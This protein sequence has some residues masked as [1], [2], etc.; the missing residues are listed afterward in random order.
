[1]GLAKREMPRPRVS[2]LMITYNHER[3]IQQA[4]EGVIMQKP[5]FD[6]ELV[7][8]EDK[9]TDKTRAVVERLTAQYP[10][11]MRPIYHEKNVGVARNHM[12]CLQACRGEYIAYCEGDDYWT[13]PDKL[14]KQV[15]FLD[16]N[17]DYVMC[18]HRERVWHELTHE[19]KDTIPWHDLRDT[20]ELEDVLCEC[21]IPTGSVCYRR[22]ALK[23]IPAW[24]L[25]V[26]SGDM[27]IY[28]LLAM[29]GKIKFFPDVMAVYRVHP[30]GIS[31]LYVGWRRLNGRLY[32]WN[33]L[34]QHLGDKYRFRLR[35]AKANEYAWLYHRLAEKQQ[36]S[37]R[38]W[39]GMVYCKLM[40]AWYRRPPGIGGV[41]MHLWQGVKRTVHH[42]TGG[43]W[44][45]R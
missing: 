9:S 30:G 45:G 34:E 44:V 26:E 7:V 23:A 42:V 24:A 15:S 37:L 17:P 29:H 21:F 4:I 13:D 25:E 35:L 14:Q 12:T 33:S 31:N 1:M 10:S 40:S 5:D 3:F 20:Y 39:A 38:R 8:G 36:H 41:I 43:Q 18:F 6:I 11:V 28:A 19:M 27:C 32:L 16:T 2:V 22:Q